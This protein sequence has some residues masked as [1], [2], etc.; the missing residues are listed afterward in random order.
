MSPRCHRELIG[1][2]MREHPV[3]AAWDRLRTAPAAIAH[4]ELWRENAGHQPAS[5]YRLHLRNDEPFPVFAKRCDATSGN[6][7]RICYEEIVPRL[8]VTSPTYLGSVEE[9]D[10]T[11]WFFVEDV[12][13]EKLS[14]HDPTHRALASRWLGRLHR[15]G[16]R[17]EA[18]R[19]LPEGGLHRYL[20]CLR[21]SRDRIEWNLGNPALSSEQHQVLAR[22]PGTLDRLE[23]SWETVSRACAPLPETV[24][25]GD[26]R[27][28]NVR[29]RPGA[30]GP[31]LY[32]LDWELAGWGVPVADLAPAR[33]NTSL[34]LIDPEVYAAEVLGHGPRL[35]RAAVRQL[36]MIGF[37]VRRLAAIEWDTLSLHFDDPRCLINPV[38]SLGALEGELT[39]ALERAPEWLE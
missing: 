15:T 8:G 33:G 37:V 24:V 9:P 22:L 20:K 27:P 29:I 4:V 28:K 3:H 17:I 38:S 7:E 1:A 19:R 25:H 35:T 13:R 18:G 11:F 26:F 34:Q 21:D 6:V 32:A 31:V 30:S 12:G 23:D 16:A 2:E 5:L 39:E 36:S 10:G 14:A